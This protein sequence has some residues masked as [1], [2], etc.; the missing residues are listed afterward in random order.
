MAARA[1]SAARLDALT[2]LAGADV[3]LSALGAVV[4][5]DVETATTAR[6][7]TAVVE[8]ARVLVVARQLRVLAVRREG[9]A[10][11]DRAGIVVRR[12]DLV[13][14]TDAPTGVA[15]RGAVV[16]E[17][18]EVAV[19]ARRAFGGRVQA[20]ARSRFA[21]VG[22]ADVV[23]IAD[24]VARDRRAHAFDAGVADRALVA[25]VARQRV[26]ERHASFG[27]IAA[28]VRAGVVVVAGQR[29]RHLNAT[30]HRGTAEHA[31]AD[32]VVVADERRTSLTTER[33]VTGLSAAALVVVVAFEILARLTA[34]GGVTRLVSVAHV[35]VLARQRVAR[36]TAEKRVARLDPV[37]DVVVVASERRTSDAAE[38]GIANLFAVALVT[39]VALER[40]TVDAAGLRVAG[41]LAVARVVV[42][43]RER[44]T[45]DAAHFAVARLE[46]VADVVVVADRRL[47]ADTGAELA[48]IVRGTCVAIAARLVVRDVHAPGERI[49]EVR[50]AGVAVVARTLFRLRRDDL[51]TTFGIVAHVQAGA[52]VAV[53]A[54]LVDP[55]TGALLARVG[56]RARAV[57]VARKGVVREPAGVRELAVLDAQDLLCGLEVRVAQVVGARVVVVADRRRK[58]RHT[59]LL[60]VADHGPVARILVFALDGRTLAGTLLTLVT[61]GARAIV[62]AGHVTLRDVDTARE[63]ITDILGAHV[64]VVALVGAHDRTLA[65]GVALRVSAQ[66]A[67]VADQPDERGVDALAIKAGVI[68]ARVVVVEVD[69]RTRT[70][71]LP[72]RDDAGVVFTAV[73]V[74]V[75]AEALVE[76]A[77]AADLV[78]AGPG[79][80]G[81]VL[82]RTVELV[83]RLGALVHLITML[84]RSGEAAV[85]AANVV[86]EVAARAL[87][88]VH[89]ASALA[90][91]RRTAHADGAL[92]LFERGA[93]RGQELF[94]ARVAAIDDRRLSRQQI[95]EPVAIDVLVAQ[96]AFDALRRLTVAHR[97]VAHE[98]TLV[99]LRV[100][101]E[102]ML[103]VRVDTLAGLLVA[104][105]RLTG[106][107]GARVGRDELACERGRVAD[108]DRA[109]VAVGVAGHVARF[110]HA[111]DLLDRL[112]AVLIPR[113]S[114]VAIRLVAVRIE[115]SM[116]VLHAGVDQ[117]AGEYAFFVGARTPI[118]ADA[119]EGQPENT[120]GHSESCLHFS[121][122]KPLP[123]SL[124][125]VG[126]QTRWSIAP[127]AHDRFR[128]PHAA[129]S[130]FSRENAAQGCCSVEITDA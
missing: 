127:M 70:A 72:V 73:V 35:L 46:A 63:R 78:D 10:G 14:R 44:R 3:V 38:G 84:V 41:L 90:G 98:P 95:E 24:L 85:H 36:L 15:H 57:I 89:D 66:L 62:V 16:D 55:D 22:R 47:T 106:L 7:H 50:G 112:L 1:V 74:V 6:T 25:V 102:T 121:P 19:V 93:L 91:L 58:M 111:T 23:V 34:E 9:V 83:V 124:G 52:D 26:V 48:C 120:K 18:T 86:V 39:V 4:H 130:V 116:R 42:V 27:W 100:A 125:E 108:L 101:G 17:R 104:R 82:V 60:V 80:A 122:P 71:L 129:L 67:V 119:A 123:T 59:A 117:I 128:K 76:R 92:T 64:S 79:E 105:T 109:R 94:E 45:S 113:G 12:A 77:L 20:R 40:H 30:E 114:D 103:D 69:R 88:R 126:I 96:L 31:V 99:A 56:V 21:G 81:R 32:V 33:R 51:N 107:V 97:S 37:A 8:R 11:V 87:A 28:V 68:G 118:D 110:R 43:A 53:V 61:F 2:R 65:V 13:A 75:A 54:L 115:P 49:A 29:T 5:V